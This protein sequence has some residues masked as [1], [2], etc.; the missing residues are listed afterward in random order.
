[1]VARG[2]ERAGDAEFAGDVVV[3]EGVADE[4]NLGGWDTEA[5]DQITTKSEFAVGMNVIEASDV[6]E[7]GREAEVRDDL[8]E[9]LVTISG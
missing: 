5:G 9:R 4:E 1:M 2:D 6:V 3:M 7:V 8:V